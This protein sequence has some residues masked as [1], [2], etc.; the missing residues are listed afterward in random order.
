M[1][2]TTLTALLA[3]AAS[4]AL[5]EVKPTPKPIYVKPSATASAQAAALA[6]QQQQQQQAQKQ[7]QGQQQTATGGSANN[8]N[9]INVEGSASASVAG[10]ACSVGF[11]LGAPGTGAIGATWSDRECKIITEANALAAMGLHNEA[12]T[13]LTHIP[14]IAATM[15]ATGILAGSVVRPKMRPASIS[16]GIGAE[17]VPMTAIPDHLPQHKGANLRAS[18]LFTVCKQTGA[19]K[20]R[21][22]LAPGADRGTATAACKRYLGVE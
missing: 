1:K 5:A 9:Q 17:P 8:S 6:A 18:S 3:L 11:S 20:L 4:G 7:A 14:R 19:R 13:H 15:A 16:D 12:R 22:Q 2:L 10:A 21:V